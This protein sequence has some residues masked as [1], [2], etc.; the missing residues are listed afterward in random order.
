MISYYLYNN[1]LSK[2]KLYAC[3]HTC[4]IKKILSQQKYEAI[5]NLIHVTKYTVHWMSIC[6]YLCIYLYV[7]IIIHVYHQHGKCFIYN[8]Y[9]CFTWPQLNNYIFAN[10]QYECAMFIDGNIYNY[11]NHIYMQIWLFSEHQCTIGGQICYFKI[12]MSLYT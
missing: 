7:C 4:S 8:Q 11:L 2:S 5:S 6:I 10:L 3:M 9:N 12:Y 1:A